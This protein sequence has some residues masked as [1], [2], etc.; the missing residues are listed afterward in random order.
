M[1]RTRIAQDEVP[2]VDPDASESGAVRPAG[3]TAAGVVEAVRR[4]GRSMVPVLV[5][6]VLI[7]VFTA[8]ESRF[9][10]TT[11]LTVMLIQA[12]P[13]LM[14]ALGAT[15][16]VLMGSIDLSVG[17]IAALAAAASAVLIQN[18]GYGTAGIL[19]AIPIGMAL[20]GVNA[21]CVLWLRLP[22]F[23]VTLGT[24]SIFSGI[25]LHVLSGRA[26]FVQDLP[27]QWL[28]RGDLFPNIPNIFLVALVAWA[29]MVLV[30]RYTRF[31]R[32]LIAIGAGEPVAALSGVPVRRYKAV[33]FV[34]SGAFAG[35]GGAFLLLQLGSAT[36]SLG[37]SFLLNSVAAI[38]IG[39]TSLSGG[40]GGASRTLLG[41][42]LLSVIS[43]GLNV[44]GVSI[45][46]QDILQGVVVVLA[47]LVTIDRGRMRNQIK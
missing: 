11:N 36:P 17:A 13:L 33:T 30:N 10:S 35:C 5:L 45:F 41:V 19:A 4:W 46:T 40:V 25:T 32:Y 12:G 23:I 27:L 20:G 24:L 39:G 15:F 31:G 9:I 3:K 8:F 47:V 14:I 6:P 16:V 1:N 28:G 7:I 22:S 43:N 2:E 34:V 18:H 44:T 42:A 21:F 29:L 37:N 26:L 38:V